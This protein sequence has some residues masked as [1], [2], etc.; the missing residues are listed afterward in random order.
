MAHFVE[1][2]LTHM[3]KPWVQSLV[4]LISGRHD[5]GRFKFKTHEVQ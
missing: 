1:F 4:P 2:C 5:G 3:K